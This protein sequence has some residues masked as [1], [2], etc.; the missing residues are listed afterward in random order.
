M[1]KREGR[2]PLHQV[3]LGLVLWFSLKGGTWKAVANGWFYLVSPL[4]II[5]YKICL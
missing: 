3:I 2:R 4:V 1:R 5:L